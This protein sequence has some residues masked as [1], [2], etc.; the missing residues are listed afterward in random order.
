MPKLR[1]PPGQQA[2]FDEL[3]DYTGGAR[4]INAPQL[5]RFW[6]RDVRCVRDWLAD[7]GITR[8]PLGNGYGYLIRDVA[9]A[10]Y[11]QE[12]IQDNMLHFKGA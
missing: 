10:M 8:H 7:Q 12:E 6:G 1:M 5:A 9:R 2:M 3:A 11:M 4:M